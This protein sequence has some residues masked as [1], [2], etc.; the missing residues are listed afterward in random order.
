MLAVKKLR[1]GI[2]VAASL[3]VGYH[4]ISTRTPACLRHHVGVEQEHQ[5]SSTGR[6]RSVRSGSGRSISPALGVSSK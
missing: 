4:S 5:P 6:G 1:L 3:I 2:I